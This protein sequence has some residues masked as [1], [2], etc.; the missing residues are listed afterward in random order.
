MVVSILDGIAR[1]YG[2]S[3]NICNL[4]V[5][6]VYIYIYVINMYICFYVYM[7]YVYIYICYVYIYIHIIYVM[8]I[9]IYVY[10][11]HYSI[12]GRQHFASPRKMNQAIRANEVEEIA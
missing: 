7:L 11:T 1:G 8:C 12:T 4:P 9:Y 2:D 3:T 10:H 5:L 6:C